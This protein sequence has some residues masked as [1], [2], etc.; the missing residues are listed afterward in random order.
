MDDINTLFENKSWDGNQFLG[1]LNK[2]QVSP[3]VLLHR[4]TGLISNFLGIKDIF[5]NRFQHDLEKDRFELTKELYLGSIVKPNVSQSWFH[6]CRRISGIK[7]L[8]KL[9][10]LCGR[11]R[12]E[13]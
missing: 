13:T 6:Y 12:R 7:L 9:Q 10:H 3:E 11:R 1:L 2:Y 4:M 5:Y 8:R